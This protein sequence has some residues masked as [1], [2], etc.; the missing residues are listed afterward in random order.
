MKLKISQEM[1]DAESRRILAAY[2]A[3]RSRSHEEIQKY[4]KEKPTKKQEEFLGLSCFEALY[5]GSAGGGKSSCLLLGAVSCAALGGH[6]LVLR[7]TFSDLNLPGAIMDRSHSWLEGTDAH[8]SGQDKRWTFPSGGSVQF[9]YLDSEKDRFRYQGA[10]FHQVY[11]DELTQFTIQQYTYL[12]SRIRKTVNEQT[13]LKVRSA[14]NPGGVGHDWVLERFVNS[15]SSERKFIPAKLED[16]PHLDQ[17]SYREALEKLDATTRAQLL[18]GL[19]I[20]DDGGQLYSFNRERNLVKEI[21]RDEEATRYILG[22]DLGASSKEATTAFCVVSYSARIPDKIWI[23]ES[24]CEADLIPSSVAEIIKKLNSSYGGFESIVCDAGALGKGYV[25]EFRRRHSLPVRAAEKRDKLGYRRLINGDFERG[26]LL[27]VEPKNSGLVKELESLQWD[28]K[29]LDAQPG[30]PDHLTDCMLY[31]TREA[32]AYASR[33]PNLP[34]KDK[35]EWAKWEAERMKK[36]A[37]MSKVSKTEQR[38]RG[39]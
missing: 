11:F 36:E 3:R 24:F 21:E 32:K 6:A 37:V 8:W 18:D 1:S 14:S 38:R 17:M 15:S 2:L 4:L 25:E 31:A 35:N 33:A 23:V 22:I 26:V 7:K 10:E 39:R 16:N 29:G 30:Q 19:W 12:I 13:Q 27:V 28:S 5:G 20:R 34:P 9:G